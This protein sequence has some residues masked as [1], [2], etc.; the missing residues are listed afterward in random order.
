MY[1]A[2]PFGVL[3]TIPSQVIEVDKTGDTTTIKSYDTS[4]SFGVKSYFPDKQVTI[5]GDLYGEKE[6]AEL[7]NT[8]A[9]VLMGDL[10]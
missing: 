7:D 10:F 9:D 1:E 8:E 2:G 4:K 3:S 6:L 5:Q